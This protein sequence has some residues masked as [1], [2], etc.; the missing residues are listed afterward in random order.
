[1]LKRYAA[2]FVI[3]LFYFTDRL[4]TWLIASRI[5]STNKLLPNKRYTMYSVFH[6]D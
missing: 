2:M 4:P 1:M 3:T 5:I 6:N